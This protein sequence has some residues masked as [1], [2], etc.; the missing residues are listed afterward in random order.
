MM[1]AQLLANKHN[2][3]SAAEAEPS[4]LPS[5]SHVKFMDVSMQ[6]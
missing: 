1:I 3:M 4:R 6:T 5:I 2:V